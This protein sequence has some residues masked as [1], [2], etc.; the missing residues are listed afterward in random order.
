VNPELAI[1]WENPHFIAVD[2]PAGLLSVPATTGREPSVLKLLSRLYPRQSH[3]A[4]HRIDRDTSGV[5]LVARDVEAHREA[6]RWFEKHL[7]KKEYLAL[8]KGHPRLP[9]F[10]VNRPIEGKTALS[11]VQIIERFGNQGPSAAFLARVRIATGR[12]HQ[13]RIHLQAEGYPV[14]GDTKYGGPKAHAGIHFGRFALHA[15][16]LVLPPESEQFGVAKSARDLVA[17]MPSDFSE[18][19]AWFRGLGNHPEIGQ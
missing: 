18:W 1:L 4:V 13:I 11:Q 14:L 17:P 5:L 3:L 16:R 19:T 6:N 12:R 9:A 2:K 15:E 8:A 7:I 10:R